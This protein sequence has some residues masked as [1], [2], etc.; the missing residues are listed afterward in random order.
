M[1]ETLLFIIVAVTVFIISMV[2]ARTDYWVIQMKHAAK[3]SNS[4]WQVWYEDNWKLWG[5]ATIFICI[6][7]LAGIAILLTGQLSYLFW[8]PSFWFLW[9]V[10]HDCALGYWLDGDIFHV[11]SGKID[12]WFLAIAI[13]N[14]KVYFGVKIFLLFMTCTPYFILN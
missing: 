5:N 7:A 9:W 3:R 4:Y 12:Q 10:V 2:E 14:E 11:G 1:N 8:A 6:A 13:G